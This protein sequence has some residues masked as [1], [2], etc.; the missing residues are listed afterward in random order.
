MQFGYIASVEI[1]NLV[2]KCEALSF[3]SNTGNINETSK[4]LSP[5][6]PTKT[7]VQSACKDVSQG[8]QNC[9]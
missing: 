5:Q 7:I 2:Q 8:L 1:P 4:M 3:Y 6:G 9:L